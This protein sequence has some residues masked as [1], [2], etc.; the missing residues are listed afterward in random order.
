VIRLTGSHGSARHRAGSR[1]N[2]GRL[3]VAVTLAF[4]KAGCG[5]DRS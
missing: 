5:N 1:G 4:L 2:S 3:Q